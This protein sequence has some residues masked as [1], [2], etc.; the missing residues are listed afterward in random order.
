M[1]AASNWLENATLNFFLRGNPGNAVVA[2][3]NVYLAL[4]TSAPNDDDTGVEVSGGNYARQVM[5]FSA[6]TDGVTA[7]NALV[8]FPVATATWG[9]LTHIGVRDAASGGNLL[10]H[11][12]MTPN[13]TVNAGGRMEFPVGSI[14]V[15]V[16]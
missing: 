1:V 2:P 6:P 7:N 10:Y 9:T 14:Q 13:H 16:M 11:A 15:T 8:Q 4:Y 5:T 3:T 12:P